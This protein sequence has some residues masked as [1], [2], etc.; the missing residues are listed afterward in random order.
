MIERIVRV[1]FVVTQLSPRTSQLEGT[2]PRSQR[3]KERFASH[4]PTG[5]E[6]R[7]ESPTLV[8]NETGRTVVAQ[9]GFK[10]VAFVPVVV[11]T[12]EET[13][14]GQFAGTVG[15]RLVVLCSAQFRYSRGDDIFTEAAQTA[16]AVKF[17]IETGQYLEVVSV[18]GLGVVRKDVG[19]EVVFAVASVLYFRCTGCT[20]V[21]RQQIG[22]VVR[23]IAID[24]QYSPMILVVILTQ[25]SFHCDVPIFDGFE[26]S[27]QLVGVP[28]LLVV[29]H[30]TI[31]Q[32]DD[33]HVGCIV[34][35][36]V[37]YETG[38]PT[39][40]NVVV[41]QTGQIRR[42]FKVFARPFRRIVQGQPVGHLDVELGVQCVAVELVLTVTQQTFLIQ[43]VTADDVC[44]LVRTAADTQVV[45]VGRYVLLIEF[46]EPVRVGESITIVAITARVGVNACT[47][48]SR[49][50][51]VGES[52][53][54]ISLDVIQGFFIKDRRTT[55]VGGSC[56]EVVGEIPRTYH[57][58]QLDGGGE[59]DVARVVDAGLA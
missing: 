42:A 3:F 24:R 4:I 37:Y 2:D 47:I 45:L 46:L 8:A 58:R 48:I 35:V 53:F 26:D 25:T 57:I 13:G 11:D 6:R 38:R 12:A 19:R 41:E 20:T 50:R 32:L 28:V 33:F 44:Q 49:V 55:F 51:R 15:G 40:G 59:T 16:G 31:F 36:R 22:F 21:P 9:V 1:Q 10:D 5:R 30:T 54:H 23:V 18:D 29:L 14:D 39:T 52:T 56:I 7:E 27:L 43:E 17:S 34:S